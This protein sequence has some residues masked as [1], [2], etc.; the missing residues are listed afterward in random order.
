VFTLKVN[1]E[2]QCIESGPDTPLVRV[3]REEIGIT[4][5]KFSCAAGACG[6]CTVHIDGK[7]RRS[8]MVTV[9]EAVRSS[10]VTLEGLSKESGWGEELHPVQAAWIEHQVPQCGYCQPGMIMSTAALLKRT[11][12]P[13][14][15]QIAEA[16]TNLCRCG[17]YPRARSAIRSLA[18][19]DRGDIAARAE[20]LASFLIRS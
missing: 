10:I 13:S 16:T 20:G 4:S 2:A 3:L 17:A 18:G 9:K 8:C 15:A 19:D 7:A 5:V 12:Y 1:G 14:D 6:A 11:P